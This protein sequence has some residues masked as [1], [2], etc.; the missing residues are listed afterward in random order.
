M[1]Y[2]KAAF[3]FA[4]VKTP[5]LL[6]LLA[7]SAEFILGSTSYAD[8]VNIVSVVSSCENQVCS[9]DV[10]LEHDDTGWEHYADSWQVV[11]ENGS[12]L[13]ERVL[14]HPHVNEQPFTRSL[15]GVKIPDGTSTVWIQAHDSI[16]GTNEAKYKIKL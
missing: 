5:P 3:R 7:I 13:G 1:I 16:H 15:S 12:V 10:T 14:H 11:D 9:F 4:N 2:Q 6:V 8:S